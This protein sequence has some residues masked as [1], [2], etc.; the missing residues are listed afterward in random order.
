MFVVQENVGMRNKEKQLTEEK[1]ATHGKVTRLVE[2]PCTTGFKENWEDPASAVIVVLEQLRCMTGQMLA[3]STKE[4]L[5]IG[6]GSAEN[7]TVNTTTIDDL[8]NGENQLVN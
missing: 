3:I 8:L 2:K 1:E 6:Y 7:A 4:I 5:Q